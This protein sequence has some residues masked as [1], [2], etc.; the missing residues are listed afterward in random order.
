MGSSLTILISCFS[1][2]LS[3]SRGISHIILQPISPQVAEMETP[4]AMD[5]SGEYS[6]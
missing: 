4:R 6:L 5:A 3:R 1:N 2:M